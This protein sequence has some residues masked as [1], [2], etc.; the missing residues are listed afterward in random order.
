MI[1]T[2][3]VLIA[4]I[5]LISTVA[6]SLITYF[7]TR[8]KSNAEAAN[9]Q[10][11]SYRQM[12]LLDREQLDYLKKELESSRANESKLTEQIRD[13][14]KQV[15]ELKLLVTNLQSQVSNLTAELNNA[16][17]GLN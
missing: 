10:I 14:N 2:A 7:S 5:G 17:S 1:M 11:E 15:T 13:L 3:E 8:K 4:L 6:A 16:K 12:L 9:L